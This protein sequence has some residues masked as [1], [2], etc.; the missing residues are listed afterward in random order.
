MRRFVRLLFAFWF[1]LSMALA[2]VSIAAAQTT[3]DPAGSEFGAAGSE[4]GASGDSGDAHFDVRGYTPDQIESQALTE[5]LTK[6]KLPL[7]GA[8]VLSGSQ[9]RIVVLYGFVGSDFGKADAAKKT[10]RFLHDSGVRVDN[11]INVRPELLASNPPPSGATNPNAENPPAG[12]SGANPGGLSSPDDSSSYPGPESYKAQ[13]ANPYVQQFSSMLPLL[14]LLGTLGMS[15]AGGSSGFSMGGNP[16]G[17]PSFGN[18]PYGPSGSPYGGSPFGGSPFGGSPL[19]SSP[20][21]SSPYGSSPYGSSPYGGSPYAGSPYGGS[22]YGGSP[23][24]GSPYGGSPYG[25]ASGSPYP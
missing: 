2:Q 20:Y 24:G 10:R 16:F 15:M 5:Y 23:Y 1:G 12:S 25:G 19:G 3:S 22:P 4:A 18:S 13:Q 7:V 17:S 21:G 6:R 9:G 14:A 8:Q 11:R